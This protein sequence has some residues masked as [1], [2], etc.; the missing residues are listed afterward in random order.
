MVR[1]GEW[2]ERGQISWFT[3]YR[4]SAIRYTGGGDKLRREKGEILREINLARESSLRPRSIVAIRPR[5]C[6]FNN[7]YYYYC[8]HYAVPRALR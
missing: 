1:A 2:R 4:T 7:Y 6:P 8:Y 3:I 5:V